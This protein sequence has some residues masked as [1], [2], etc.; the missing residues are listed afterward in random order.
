MN[1][2]GTY[3]SLVPTDIVNVTRTNPP[4]VGAYEYS[5]NPVVVT[6]VAGA[7]SYNGQH[8]L[9]RSTPRE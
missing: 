8:S 7:I 5:A 6:T 1:H 4:D 3:L 9:V 2:T